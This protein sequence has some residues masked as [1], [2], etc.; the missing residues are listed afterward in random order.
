MWVS[1]GDVRE[2][3]VSDVLYQGSNV[4]CSTNITKDTV[5]A[6]PWKGK[7]RRHVDIAGEG[8]ALPSGKSASG[9]QLM[10]SITLF[11]CSM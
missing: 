5:L 11:S 6:G 2:S 7:H 8:S 9:Q 4:K 10:P 3:K 1:Q